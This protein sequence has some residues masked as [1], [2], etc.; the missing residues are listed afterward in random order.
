MPNNAKGNP[1]IRKLIN[2]LTF[3]CSIILLTGGRNWATYEKTVPKTIDFINC[4]VDIH[5]NDVTTDVPEENV[6]P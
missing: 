2:V 4:G 1:Y 3:I 5:N 6:L